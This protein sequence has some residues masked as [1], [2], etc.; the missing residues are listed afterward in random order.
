MTHERE[1][2]VAELYIRGATAAEKKKILL[3]N[4]QHNGMREGKN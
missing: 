3:I 2:G 4:W 1:S